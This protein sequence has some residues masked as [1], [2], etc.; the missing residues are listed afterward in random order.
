MKN[1]VKGTEKQTVFLTHELQ[2]EVVHDSCTGVGFH[3][4]L[5]LQ[6]KSVIR[7][8]AS[9]VIMKE[10]VIEGII[11]QVWFMISHTQSLHLY[12]LFT[13]TSM[14]SFYIKKCRDHANIFISLNIMEHHIIFD[15]FIS[16]KPF[17]M[18]NMACEYFYAWQD[19][20]SMQN[21]PHM[22]NR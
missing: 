15:H 12:I 13:V 6:Q 9:S 14:S 20:Q 8:N 17:L 1:T 5:F 10:S 18:H 7:R 2:L 19:S 4:S 22:Q 3:D 21:G 16:Y 11:I